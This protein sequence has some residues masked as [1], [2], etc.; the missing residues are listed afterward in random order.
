MWMIRPIL[1]KPG[2]QEEGTLRKCLILNGKII[3]VFVFSL[4]VP[5][6]MA[7]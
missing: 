3:D 2:F 1:E 6:L 5:D 7:S 4:L